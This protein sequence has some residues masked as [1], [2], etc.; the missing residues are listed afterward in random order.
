MLPLLP[1]LILFGRLFFVFFVRYY[2][3]RP[4]PHYYLNALFF[5]VF[6]KMPKL[7][8]YLDTPSFRGSARC[9]A[10][11]LLQQLGCMLSL[12]YALILCN[13]FKKQMY[14]TALVH[15]VSTALWGLFVLRSYMI[16]H[17]CGHGSF[18]QG[19]AGAKMCNWITLKSENLL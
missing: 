5:S 1:L 6:K 4:C 7:S 19:F 14:L 11:V 16:F 17:D 12:W 15:S 10:L 3:E 2:N 9:S 8:V 18:F 13:S